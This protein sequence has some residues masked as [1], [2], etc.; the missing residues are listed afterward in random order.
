MNDVR[1]RQ[2][3]REGSLCEFGQNTVAKPHCPRRTIFLLGVRLVNCVCSRA[4]RE[5][6]QECTLRNAKSVYL[7]GGE[8]NCCVQN[9]ELVQPWWAHDQLVVSEATIEK[10]WPGAVAANFYPQY[11][12]K[13]TM[14]SRGFRVFRF[15][16][17]AA[18]APIGLARR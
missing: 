10:G 13:A 8:I 4:I 9:G 18:A 14:A 3:A 1:L 17:L 5:T 15:G 6:A 11:N 12:R 16:L 7:G 2:K